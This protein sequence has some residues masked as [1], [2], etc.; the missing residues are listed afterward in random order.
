MRHKLKHLRRDPFFRPPEE[1]DSRRG[2]LINHDN[3]VYERD[4]GNDSATLAQALEAFNADRSCLGS[5]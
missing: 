5:A 3:V 1:A 2:D 4:L